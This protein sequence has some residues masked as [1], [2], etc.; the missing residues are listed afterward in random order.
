[1]QVLPN[2]SRSPK[3]H[4]EKFPWAFNS[5][6]LIRESNTILLEMRA[7]LFF[8]TFSV[9]VVTV[10]WRVDQM[11][12]GDKLAWAEA[13]S[14]AQMS[15]LAT[16]LETEVNSLKNLLVLSFAEVEQ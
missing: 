7:I 9:F 14:R 4:F 2:Q 16:A 1:M 12:F 10:V 11:M 5:L 13:Q 8:L 6:I 3:N 15:A